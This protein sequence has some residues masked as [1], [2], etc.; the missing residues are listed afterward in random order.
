MPRS[1][2]TEIPAFWMKLCESR[3]P[4]QPNRGQEISAALDG[5]RSRIFFFCGKA[6]GR[7]GF[8]SSGK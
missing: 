3:Q 5:R 6:G 8:L 1:G 4:A 7:I 2:D